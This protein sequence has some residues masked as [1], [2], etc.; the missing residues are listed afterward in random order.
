MN[1]RYDIIILGAGIAGASC[2]AALAGHARILLLEREDFPGRHTT[3]RSAATFF[4]TIGGEQV[5]G[6]TRASRHFLLNPPED[7][8]EGPLMTPLG[9]LSIA[10]ADQL[11]SL[12][13]LQRSIANP[14]QIALLSTDEALAMVPILRPEAAVQAL[15]DGTGFNVDVDRLLQGALKTCRRLGVD[16]KL[17]CGDARLTR[18]HA[19]WKVETTLGEFSA[20]IVVNAT[21]AW[22][23]QVAQAAGVGTVGLE[24]RR[25]AA[26]TL[27]APSIPSAGW[28][29]VGDV[30]GSFYFKPDAGQILL[31]PANEDLDV[32]CDVA[33]DE[34]DIAIAV[35]RFETATTMTVTRINHRWAGLRSF[36][37]DRSPVCGFDTDAKGFFW[38]AG[39]GGYGIQTSP[40]LAAAAASLILGA[41]WPAF[42]EAEGLSPADISPARL[43]TGSSLQTA[44]S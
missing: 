8:G 9:A 32:P 33:P 37:P 16:I 30:D 29:M 35:D 10:R 36:V 42:L 4:D 20:D 28:P 17:G 40:A 7:Y 25:R 23:D 12:A 11:A 38:L 3:G 31:S 19:V 21:G 26:M 39:Q 1:D 22:A 24:P 18:A 5:R 43:G 41:P 6:L 13:A 34:M 44:R 15:Y 14:D 27:P 2:A